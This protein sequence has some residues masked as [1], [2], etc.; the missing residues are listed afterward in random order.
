MTV[1]GTSDDSQYWIGFNDI[2]TEMNFMWSDGSPVRYTNWAENE[3]NNYRQS[4]DCVG[5]YLK[6]SCL[7][8]LFELRHEKTGFLPM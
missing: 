3:P 8:I 4:E 5:M 1:L 6:V 7:S 2:L